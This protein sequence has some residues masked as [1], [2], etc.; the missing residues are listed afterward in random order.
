MRQALLFHLFDEKEQRFMK[1]IKRKDGQTTE[2][3]TTPDAS[4][5]AIW[6][7]DVLP[8]D[9]PRVVSTMTQLAEKL[10]VRTPIGGMCRYPVDYYQS[11]LPPSAEIPGNPW[12]ITTLW[13]AQ[14][15]IALAKSPADL[16]V[17]KKI[18][19]WTVRHASPSGLLPEQLHPLTGAP[20]SVSPLTWSHATYV[21]TVL[22]YLDKEREVIGQEMYRI[23]SG[24]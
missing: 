14:W 18:I 11:V 1:K 21:E 5:A 13:D 2:R 4:L 23:A 10:A 19:D 7:L 16:E 24:Q 6:L 12:I 15:R 8:A 17:A 22:K 9:D 3:D 20:I